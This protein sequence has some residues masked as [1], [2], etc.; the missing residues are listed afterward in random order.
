MYIVQCTYLL[1]WIY[2][3]LLNNF[4]LIVDRLE[5]PDSE[6]VEWLLVATW[7]TSCGWNARNSWSNTWIYLI[8]RLMLAFKVLHRSSWSIRSAMINCSGSY[9]FYFTWKP[10]YVICFFN[11]QSQIRKHNAASEAEFLGEIQIKVFKVFLLAIQSPLQLCL[12]ID[13]S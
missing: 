9:F 13:I 11:C 3:F 5:L 10:V 7:A 12:E 1:R 8:I 2:I 4:V 6:I